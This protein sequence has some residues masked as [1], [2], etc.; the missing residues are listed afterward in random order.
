MKFHLITEM[1]TGILMAWIVI[2]DNLYHRSLLLIPAL[3]FF[4]AS[5]VILMLE[6]ESMNTKQWKAKEKRIIEEIS[7]KFSRKPE[8]TNS[9]VLNS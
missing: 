8:V 6:H 9:E 2:T 5:L 1:I 7:D 4:H 3:V